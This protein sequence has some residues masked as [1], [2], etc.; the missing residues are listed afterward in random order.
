MVD[1]EE[2]SFESKRFS[3]F[4]GGFPWRKPL[5]HH[6]QQGMDS[7]KRADSNAIGQSDECDY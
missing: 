5:T 1:Q 4:A 2:L 7:R 6:R 3:L